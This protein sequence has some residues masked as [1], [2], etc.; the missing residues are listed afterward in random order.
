MLTTLLLG[1][2]AALAYFLWKKF[3]EKQEGEEQRQQR[4]GRGDDDDP[5]SGASP[6]ERRRRAQEEEARRGE[7]LRK[8]VK[9]VE[10]STREIISDLPIPGTRPR[11]SIVP[12]SNFNVRPI[13][14][15]G[16]VS[17]L[18]PSSHLLD[19]DQF[20]GRLSTNSLMV[21]E[22]LEYYGNAR[23]VL[24]AAFDGSGSM[25]EYGRVRWA[26]SLCEALIDRCV[27]QQAEFI[28]IVYSGEIKG[29]Y[30]VHDRKS[31]L[32]LKR[33]LGVILSPDGGTDTVL[34]LDTMF[35]MIKAAGL[36]EARG[37]LVTDGTESIEEGPILAR[38]KKEKVFLHTVSIAGQRDDLRRIS[39]RY[40]RLGMYSPE[41]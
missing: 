25:N 1:A 21:S 38:R 22:Y 31:A 15:V 16:E 5:M 28:L 19:D 11:Q 20:Y 37:L 30:R 13:K 9:S 8:I 29:V 24:Y 36:A 6:E 32:E 12:T 40:D 2:A 7:L 18:L 4:N 33:K 23:H 39:D 34:A 3:R 14:G 26:I 10:F 27:E 35:D 41:G 17:S